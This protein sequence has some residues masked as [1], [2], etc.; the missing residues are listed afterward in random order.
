M[1][2]FQCKKGAVEDMERLLDEKLAEIQAENTDEELK[3]DEKYTDF[4]QKI[5]DILHPGELVWWM[6]C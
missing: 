4:E 6:L 1:N 3:Q 2:E 5:R